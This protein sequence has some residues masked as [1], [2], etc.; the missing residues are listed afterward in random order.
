MS[1]QVRQFI[2]FVQHVMLQTEE[3]LARF[4]AEFQR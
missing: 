3:T 2:C 1:R 4:A